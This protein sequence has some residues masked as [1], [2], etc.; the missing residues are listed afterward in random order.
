[1]STVDFRLSVT[2]NEKDDRSFGQYWGLQSIGRVM[3]TVDGVPQEVKSKLQAFALKL[4]RGTDREYKMKKIL[5]QA[6]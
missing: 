2:E 3:S 1:M 6:S 4:P 5:Q